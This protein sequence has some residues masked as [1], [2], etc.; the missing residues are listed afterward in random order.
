MF[1]IRLLSA[2]AIIMSFIPY[3]NPITAYDGEKHGSLLTVVGNMGSVI[4]YFS[5]EMPGFKAFSN[6]LFILLILIYIG[7][8]GVLFGL[9]LP[10]RQPFRE[11]S[12]RA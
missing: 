5:T 1:Y 11:D 7:L 12:Q 6:I 10:E 3:C 2:V 9:L 8:V 4:T